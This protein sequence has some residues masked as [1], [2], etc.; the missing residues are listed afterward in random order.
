MQVNKKKFRSIIIAGIIL[1]SFN[2]T[3]AQTSAPAVELAQ[4]IAKKMKDSLNLNGNQ[5]SQVYAINLQLHNQKQLIRQQNS[6]PDS[7][8]RKI[9]RVEK[10]RDSLYRPVLGE[11]KYQLYLQK[12]RNLVNNN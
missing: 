4:K 11:P 5:R 3:H 12:K 6:N 9:Q 8:S 2:K 10:M 7:L 1:I